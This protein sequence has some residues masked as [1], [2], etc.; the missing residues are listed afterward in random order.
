M[1]KP[2]LDNRDLPGVA[3][4]VNKAGSEKRK[5]RPAHTVDF[6]SGTATFDRVDPTAPSPPVRQQTA[7]A[8]DY[9][10]RKRMP[11]SAA[12]KKDRIINLEKENNVLKEK[13]NLLKVE[14]TKMQT[15]LHRIE[16]LL[17]S[18]SHHAGET[19]ARQMASDL[20]SE[21]EELQSKNTTTKERVRKLN[22]IHRGL[23]SR[24]A[25]A[26]KP[27]KYAHVQGKLEVTHTK[28]T[29]QY[30]KAAEDLR[31]QMVVN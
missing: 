27:N 26:Q 19:D 22:V 29:Q 4:F 14:V 9:G 16:G 21:F 12:E 11:Q 31:A 7:K 2:A 28:V 15:K 10:A 17:R 30:Q 8:N 18:R 3:G 6:S 20:Q 13:E 24:P 23:A 1:S 25:T 5:L